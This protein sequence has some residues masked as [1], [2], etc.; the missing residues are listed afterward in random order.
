MAMDFS[1]AKQI[2]DT[3][4]G[5]FDDLPEHQVRA[6]KVVADYYVKKLDA[7]EKERIRQEIIKMAEA[8]GLHV[9]V[10]EEPPPKRKRK[11]KA[12]IKYRDRN[13]NTWTGV[14]RRPPWIKEVIRRGDSIEEYKVA[15]T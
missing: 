11:T 6:L 1:N 13:G 3:L 9:E 4:V 5:D 8:A 2:T 15:G 10:S 14:G 7:Q 12:P